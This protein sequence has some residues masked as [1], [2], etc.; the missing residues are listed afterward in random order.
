MSKLRKCMLV[1]ITLILVMLQPMTTFAMSLP[2]TELENTFIK[3]GFED[4][5]VSDSFTRSVE[6]FKDFE[7]SMYCKAGYHLGYYIFTDKPDS[8]NTTVYLNDNYLDTICINGSSPDWMNLD[9][10]Y[11]IPFEINID[12]ACTVKLKTWVDIDTE[13]GLY[14]AR[15]TSNS[16]A[17][18]DTSA[19]T[20]DSKDEIFDDDILDDGYTPIDLGDGNQSRSAVIRPIKVKDISYD[21]YSS[22]RTYYTMTLEKNPPSGQYVNYQ[23]SDTSGNVIESGETGIDT[24]SFSTKK[25]DSILTL[26]TVVEDYD[27]NKSEPVYMYFIP[28]IRMHSPKFNSSKTVATISWDKVKGVKY[29]VYSSKDKKNWKKVASTSKTSVRVNIKNLR[30]GEH[31]YYTVK[32]VATYRGKNLSSTSSTCA[33]VYKY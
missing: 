2:E 28:D 9:E 5:E 13:Y 12:G 23:V 8:V 24:I 7:R 27:G 17:S 19:P 30:K 10:V 22:G 16:D 25:H 29:I 1:L 14:M 26:T 32:A 15:N 11:V 20:S 21:T 3:N 4:I 6:A 18:S 31:R 33:E